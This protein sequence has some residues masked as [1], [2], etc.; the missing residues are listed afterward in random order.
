MTGPEGLS[1]QD[2]IV[3]HRGFKSHKYFRFKKHA[4]NNFDSIWY[5]HETAFSLN[6]VKIMI[7]FKRKCFYILT[8][9]CIGFPLIAE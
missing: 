2:S 7:F 8:V 5:I 9:N 6:Q 1:W 3:I 4:N